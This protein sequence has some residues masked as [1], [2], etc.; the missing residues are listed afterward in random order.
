MIVI[1]NLLT[2]QFLIE[3]LWQD[4][5][6]FIQLNYE[7]IVEDRSTGFNKI[8]LDVGFNGEMGKIFGIV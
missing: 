7:I 8:L 1:S 6:S 3:K 2:A 5:A 4:L